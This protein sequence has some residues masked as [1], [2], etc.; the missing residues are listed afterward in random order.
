MKRTL[1]LSIAPSVGN[2]EIKTLRDLSRHLQKL[3]RTYGASTM[4]AVVVNIPDDDG[5][6]ILCAVDSIQGVTTPTDSVFKGASMILFEA[7]F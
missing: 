3:T 4:V 6:R 7:V 2:S 5:P 1:D